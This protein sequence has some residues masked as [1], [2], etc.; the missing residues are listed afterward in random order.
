MAPSQEFDIDAYRYPLYVVPDEKLSVQDVFEIKGDYYQGTDLD[1]SRFATAG[2]F[3]NPLNFNNPTRTINMYR[4]CYVMI[5]NVKSWLPDEVKCLVWYGYGAPDSTFLTPLWP[6]MTEMP[7]YYD[8]GSRY[9]DFDRTSGWW[10]NTYV[11][12][13]AARNY[14]YAIELIHERRAEK[15]AQQYEEVPQLQE[16]WA[17]MIN[18]GQTEEAI[19]E[20][21]E[22]ANNAANEWFEMWL[23]LGDELVSDLV[24]DRMNVD[25]RIARPAT[26]PSGIRTSWTAP[27]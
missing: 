5:A 4:T 6:T 3:G 20:L 26:T 22:Y 24:W 25:G 1:A 17:E 23:D 12:D 11:Q 21:T 19:A 8:H 18:N 15:M 27:R 9:E 7:S 16:K 2:D 13:Q 10:I 14:D